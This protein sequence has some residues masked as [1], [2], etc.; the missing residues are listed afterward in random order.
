MRQAPRSSD[1]Q[2][3]LPMAG[4]G[5]RFTDAGY[6]TPKPLIPIHGV[7]MFKIVLANIFSNKVSKV[8]VITRR[9][10]DLTREI[11]QLAK[12]T[13]IDFDLV[14]IDYTTDGPASTV[15]LAQDFLDPEKPV[16]VANSDQYVNTSIDTFYEKLVT[17]DSVGCIMT[18]NDADPKWSFVKLDDQGHVSKVREKE[19][20]SNEATVG[21]YGFKKSQYMIDA[22]NEMRESNDRV[23][24]EFYV[25]PAYNY[26]IRSGLPI[27]IFN[28]G[29]VR[30][31]MFGLGIP[32]DYEF[33]V[34]S[35]ESKKASESAFNLFERP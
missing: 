11:N 13:N 6:H 1:I 25:A 21:I 22:I 29:D 9:E 19:V 16:V 12:S 7:P 35:N 8:V 24:G 10:W 14:E 31:V 32:E 15:M 4:L 30:D 3:I 2:I 28:I 27:D 34:K 17:S 26:L 18:M 20:I 23:N 5:T 33:F